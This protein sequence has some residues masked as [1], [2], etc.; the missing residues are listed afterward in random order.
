MLYSSKVTGV[1]Y[2]GQVQ[3]TL[4]NQS[5]VFSMVDAYLKSMIHTN[6]VN[7]E[8]RLRHEVGMRVLLYSKKR[9]EGSN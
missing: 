2:I 9:E 7:L 1:F 8:D 5:K 4:T 3:S 6:R